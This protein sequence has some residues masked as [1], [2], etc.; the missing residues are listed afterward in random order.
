[1]RGDRE[2]G[3]IDLREDEVSWQNALEPRCREHAGAVSLVIEP[4]VRDL[5]GFS[6]RRVLPAAECRAVGPFVFFDEMG[7]ARFAPGTGL[8]VR[9]HP[10][11]GLSTVTFLFEGEILHRD[12]LGFVQPIRPGELNW[13]TAGRGVVHSE[14][15]DPALRASGPRLHGIQSW[16]ALPEGGE[17]VD[18]AFEHHPAEALP[19]TE[20]GGARVRLILGEAYGLGSPVRTPS[21]TLYL[22]ARV[23][24]GGELALPHAPELAAYLV[25]GAAAIAD[26]ALTP[27]T[28]AVVDGPATL[29]ASRVSLVMVIGGESV[30]PRHLWWNF[31]S[32][33]RE[34]IER[35]KRDW[36][37]RAFAPVPGETE[38]I[39]LPER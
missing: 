23:P 1:V 20:I 21:P 16:M 7:P 36:S 30:G 13:M 10:H 14:R 38:F 24:P 4:R 31:V 22:E 9:P 11:I 34:R 33:S 8:D 17:E 28:L 18:P 25:D 5:G 15:T 26:C 32:S 27:N 12:S 19:T 2:R 39:P 6:V 29:R 3:K 37:N 35:A